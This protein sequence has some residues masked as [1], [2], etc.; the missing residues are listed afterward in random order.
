VS[1]DPRA[2]RTKVHRDTEAALSITDL[3]ARVDRSVRTTF[4][5]EI[6]ITGEIRSLKVNAN[7]H[8]FIDLVDPG[9][10]QGSGAPQLSVKCWANR[11]RT[12]R[13]TLERLGITLEAG[14]VVRARGEVEFY[15]VRGTV[16]F[17]LAELDT[18]A[19]MGK[20]AAERARLIQALVDEDL[21]DR[22]RRMRVATLPLRVGLV[23][24]PGTE[25]FHD[26]LGGLRASG[27]AFAV[28]VAPT[29]VQGKDAPAMVAAAVHDLQTEPI[30]VIVIVRGGGSK[31]D[32][33]AFDQEPVARAI[34]TSALPVWTGIGH[35]GDQ[36]V[37]DE[38]ANR[39]C[40]T[41]TECGQELAR[42]AFDYWRQVEA[43]GAALARIARDRVL[44]AD[45]V[46]AGRQR[47]M[48]TGARNQLDRHTDGLAHR[49]KALR[50]LVRGQV[51]T[52]AE[53]LVVA[54]STA[55]RAAD[56]AVRTRQ[57]A[58]EA[59]V[60]RLAALPARRLE[61]EEL[62]GGQRRRLL[63]AYDYQRQLERGY[64]VTRG[65]DGSVL[66]SVLGQAAG[67]VLT[68]QLAD[69]TIG[70]V[71]TDVTP[72]VTTIPTPPPSERATDE[73][74]DNE[75]TEGPD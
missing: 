20:V 10:A 36:S 51:D 18:D 48:S 43:A 27:L 37:A 72:V 62:R 21:F 15:K 2:S 66:R 19:L 8:C 67:A 14:M 63:G 52:H 9:N 50:S 38:V 22:Q 23:A 17:K 44:Q 30:D 53:R 32:L 35:T 41:P 26:F 74:T 55:G 3:Y 64:S 28:T 12:I 29:A 4:P 75:T 5:D 45:K 73:P 59:R 16:D 24:S 13:S 57:D 54:G 42:L 40:I 70:S 39:S 6:W 7:G 47:A 58:L 60:H 56:R 11:W 61:V 31:A 46:L 33:A 68:T 34:A 1:P 71:A 49:A 25:G 65:P 69:G